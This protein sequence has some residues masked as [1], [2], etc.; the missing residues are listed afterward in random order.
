[1]FSVNQIIC[2]DCVEVLS[3]F[4]DEF[5]DITISSPPY[6]K[7]RDYANGN[8]YNFLLLAEQLYRVVKEGG[9]VAWIRNDTVEDGS[10]TGDTFKQTI[11]FMNVGFNLYDVLI[12]EKS[13]VS[14]PANGRYTGIHEYIILLS[15]G[16]PKV[17]NPIKDVPK[18]WEGS[19]GK[20]TTRNQDG[21][22]TYQNLENEGKAKSGRDDTGKYGYKQRTTIWKINNGFGFNTKDEIA[23]EH[24]AIFPET[25][26]HDI[27]VS[28]SN[29]GDLVLDPFCGSGT[30][31]K[32]AKI[33][34]RN[35]IGIDI[36]QRYCDISKQRVDNTEQQLTLVN[37]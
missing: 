20:L 14:Y 1:M 3:T 6:G 29:E 15:K 31:L 7:I 13:G 23:K 21:S 19:W 25:L 28:W 11:E 37:V 33:L 24:P 30:T 16:K 12:W 36:S 35:Y 10:K 34:N 32:M 22:L 26:C 2:G 9:L 18:L 27:I 8:S 4:P 17:F 5:V